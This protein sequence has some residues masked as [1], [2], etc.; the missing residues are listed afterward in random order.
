MHADCELLSFAEVCRAA[1]KLKLGKA[2][3]FEGIIPEMVVHA[4]DYLSIILVNLSNL[5]LIHG[6][7]PVETLNAPNFQNTPQ[8]H[9]KMLSRL[10]TL[11]T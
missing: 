11:C 5:C 7:V 8:K 10:S 3:G 2:P 6:C 4:G 9:T 1:S